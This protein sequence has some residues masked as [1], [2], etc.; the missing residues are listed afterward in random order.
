MGYLVINALVGWVTLGADRKGV[1]SAK[2]I[3]HLSTSPIPGRSA[4]TRLTAFLYSGVPERHFWLTAVIG[5]PVP[6]SAFAG[7]P[8]LLIILR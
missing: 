6:A 3:N 4:S 5:G 7:G 2:W 8:A 1:P